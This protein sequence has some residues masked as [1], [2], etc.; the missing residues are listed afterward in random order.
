MGST[1]RLG[2]V[3]IVAAMLVPAAPASA[4]LQ[5]RLSA[6]TGVNAQGYFGPLVDAFAADLTAG[7]FHSA[8]IPRNSISVGLEL[9][10]MSVNFSNP[11]RTFMA[12]TEGAFQPQTSAV[13]PTV[14][15]DTEPVFIDGF[16]G[17]MYAFPGGFNIQSFSTAVPQLR[18]GSFY[19]TEAVFRYAYLN[20]GTGNF[21]DIRFDLYG[22][23]LR[24]S[25][26]QYFD[27]FP[28]DVAASI[29][30]QKFRMAEQGASFDIVTVNT[31]NVGLQVSKRFALAKSWGLAIEPYSGVSFDRFSFLAQYEA[32]KG[33][34]AHL[35]FGWQNVTQFTLGTT[36]QI[37]FLDISGEYNVLDSGF[38]VRQSA[39]S[40]GLS[41]AYTHTFTP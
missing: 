27:G 14:I 16:D 3:T 4:Q 11:D 15:G 41:V 33:D 29:F 34:R 25:I 6:Y 30:A 20:R 32:T 10:G 5:Q 26:S 39:F 40:I 8:Y 1:V 37:A 28:V 36:L 2:V 22:G 21:G 7:L 19:G 17:L 9:R 18:V 35:S 38:D 13:A 31:V 23:G 12:V 24:H